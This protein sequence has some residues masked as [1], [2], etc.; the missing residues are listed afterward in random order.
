MI[1]INY[2][3]TKMDTCFVCPI[4]H[5]CMINPYIDNEGNTY[6]YSAI[7]EWLKNNNTSP[8][9]R[10]YLDLSHLKPNRILKE[11]IELNNPIT[12]YEDNIISNII[13]EK[14]T[15]NDYNYFKLN[16]KIIEGTEYPP[17]DIVA[18]ID[19]SGSMNTPA[20]VEQDGNIVDIGYTILDITKH[21]L[22]TIVESMKPNDRISIVVFSNDARVLFPLTTADNINKSIITN[23]RTEGAT[24]IWA[25]LNVGLQ[26]FTDTDRISAMLFLTDG[27]PSAHLLPPQGIL[28]CLNKKMINNKVNIYTFGFGYSLDTDLLINIAKAGNGHFSFIPDSGFVGTIFIHALAHIN[29]TVIHN[30]Q[31]DHNNIKCLGDNANL[32]TIH[33]GQSRTLI[34]KSKNENINIKIMYDGKEQ[35]IDSFNNVNTNDDLL[36]HIM[37][38]ELVEVLEKRSK[39]AIDEYLFNYSH[40]D[41]DL[42]KDFKEQICLA[43]DDKYFTKWGKNYI[44]SFK[45]AHSQE[46]CNNFKDKSI[47]IYG[48][49]LFQK[50][51][52]KIDDIYTN[53]P[54]PKP[55]NSVNEFK[56]SQQQFTTMFNN[57]NGGC[58][59]PSSHILMTGNYYKQIDKITKND[60]IVD[61]K[62]NIATV[63]CIIKINCNGKCSM[64]NI[65][66]LLITPYHPIK[67]NN[68]WIFPKD[69]DNNITDYE[70]DAI[71][72]LILND[73]H[74][75]VINN[76]ISCTLGHNIIENDV[77][78]HPFFGTDVVINDLKKIKG[79]NE[80]Y[81]TLN[82]EDFIRDNDT[83][84][85][86]NII[87]K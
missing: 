22:I 72:N 56:V 30:L 27:L 37:R 5:T 31:C 32:T 4:T 41:N 40:I 64:V 43:I 65:D 58:F 62:G 87:K 75:I 19:I 76:C 1:N 47:Q 2:L 44:N 69:I 13:T 21:A 48:G 73:H 24:N 20:L 28:H 80:G 60:K 38:L 34:F 67:L 82:M 10:N 78:K 6:E 53:M 26:Q 85:V 49:Q 45:D 29:T 63:I 54:P 61:V 81:I 25:G 51:K 36:F 23:L 66:G 16:I 59:H 79:F 11:A 86:I 70:C 14:T 55:S 18:V 71:Y 9:T 33:Y 3:V 77:I 50:M 84:K 35:I 74:T 39:K 52:D 57:V 83:G 15:I 68:E 46:R 7:C 42:M 17:I 12:K 8:I